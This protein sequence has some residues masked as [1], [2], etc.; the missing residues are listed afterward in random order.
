[1]FQQTP[2]IDSI[3]YERLNRIATTSTGHFLFIIF[4]TIVLLASWYLHYSGYGFAYWLVILGLPLILTGITQNYRY[5]NWLESRGESFSLLN[6]L[7]YFTVMIATG[8]FLF[9]LFNIIYGRGYW[10]AKYISLTGLIF[11]LLGICGHGWFFLKITRITYQLKLTR[12]S[13]T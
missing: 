6:K 11:V 8:L 4:G 9:I 5:I 2:G 3:G 12:S 10:H 7:K 1:M 13:D